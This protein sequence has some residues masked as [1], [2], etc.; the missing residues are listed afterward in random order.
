VLIRALGQG[1]ALEADIFTIPF[2][3]TGYLLLCSDGL[4]NV[5]SDKDIARFITEAPNLHHACQS[6]VEAANAA[7]GPDNISVVLAQMI[8]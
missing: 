6:M 4:W 2:P 3:Q 5:V 7:G 8:G 1:E